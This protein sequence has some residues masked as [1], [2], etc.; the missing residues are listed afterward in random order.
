MNYAD[1][2]DEDWKRLISEARLAV[3]REY[4]DKQIRQIAFSYMQKGA[5]GGG[6]AHGLMGTYIAS[7]VDRVGREKVA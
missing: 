7:C 6:N 4:T 5:N 2:T 1:W 3:S